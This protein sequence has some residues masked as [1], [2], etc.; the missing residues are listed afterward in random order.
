MRLVKITYFLAIIAFLFMIS[1]NNVEG[2]TWTVRLDGSGDYDEIDNAISAASDGDSI[3]IGPGNF[4]LHNYYISDEV[5]IYG[6]GVDST[7]INCYY[8]TSDYVFRVNSNNVVLR[9][10]SLNDE[11]KC[12]SVYV[13]NSRTN[14]LIDNIKIYNVYYES[15]YF[16]WNSNVIFKNSIVG[17][18]ESVIDSIGLRTNGDNGVIDN[19]IFFGNY[20]YIDGNSN[21]ITN[22]Q[23]SNTD[24]WSIQLYGTSNILSGNTVTNSPENRDEGSGQQNQA[25]DYLV[26]TRTDS[27]IDFSSTSSSFYTGQE[28]DYFGV[29]WE[30]SFFVEGENGGGNGS[31]G[32][33][34]Y[35]E[36]YWESD[37]GYKIT[38]DGNVYRNYLDCYGYEDY[39]FGQWMEAGTHSIKIEM[40]ECTGDARARLEWYSDN[41]PMAF[42]GQY[43][44]W[45]APV[46]ADA[47]NFKSIY[48]GNYQNTIDET[49]TFE[50]SHFIMYYNQEGKT[51]S[52]VID[53]K[54]VSNY[55][56]RIYIQNSQNIEISNSNF[57]YIPKIYASSTN[58]ITIKN[59]DFING[60]IEI[61]GD[62]NNIESNTFVNLLPQS[63]Y[64][65]EIY[66]SGTGNTISNNNVK[67]GIDVYGSLNHVHNNTIDKGQGNG[68]YVESSNG[69]IA[70]NT[71]NNATSYGIYS[72]NSNHIDG[73]IVFDSS[74]YAIYVG[75]VDGTTVTERNLFKGSCVVL[76]SDLERTNTNKKVIE[77]C[78]YSNSKGAIWNLDSY[79]YLRHSS[80]MSIDSINYENIEGEYGIRIENSNN[81]SINSV[82][83][84]GKKGIS[85]DGIRISSS[86]DISIANSEFADLDYCIF[87]NS[88]VYLEIESN[89][90]S[91]C[92]RG[93]YDSY[94]GDISIEANTFR[95]SGYGVYLDNTIFFTIEDN[96]FRNDRI[97]EMLGTGIGIILD[98]AIHGSVINNEINGFDVGGIVYSQVSYIET[99][100]NKIYDNG[101]GIDL[102]DISS[103]VYMKIHNNDIYDNQ[104]YGMYSDGPVDARFN[105]WGDPSGPYQ[106]CESQEGCEGNVNL[107]GKGNPVNSNVDAS[108][109]LY[110][111]GQQF[112]IVNSMQK[113]AYEYTIPVILILVVGIVG[114]VA[115]R[116]GWFENWGDNSFAPR[117][118]YPMAPMSKKKS[119]TKPKTKMITIEC[120]NCSE[121]IK[122]EKKGGK[123]KITCSSCGTSGE[124]EL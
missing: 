7:Y 2:K 121:Q 31:D 71:V 86:D 10:F 26:G 95:N 104:Q 76:Y 99:Q 124:V 33:E 97:R 28:K 90:F 108:E 3:D 39:Y 101:V 55:D 116:R 42:Q 34:G 122:L 84:S 77:N 14:V 111:S 16:N 83:I 88:N 67:N 18:Q 51:I 12:R 65:R 48:V 57:D 9:D 79:I 91:N 115:W 113:I 17:V 73:N 112:T 98:E 106:R 15:L 32:D 74:N 21:Q 1:S 19:N 23:I 123:Q 103:R 24:D 37:D 75:S 46:D 5:T 110:G 100:N 120:T 81:I 94:S 92:N 109:Q 114:V 82:K 49:N 44:H 118:T 20:I 52:N 30:G 58:G 56:Y 13:D 40:L 11:T 41:E 61:S 53:S 62:N 70:Y 93:I 105:Y 27:E 107:E 78:E 22:N 47:Q 29:I 85:S 45:K 36:F 68:L 6:S 87:G 59:C 43:Y 96:V 63:F 4:E 119:I 102:Y 89:K 60:R 35:V 72:G 54:K 25:F 50:G 66:V 117:N 38:I 8:D 64:E 80:W 69:K